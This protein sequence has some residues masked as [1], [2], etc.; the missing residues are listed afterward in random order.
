MAVTA[1]QRV[2]D[3]FSVDRMIEAYE[4]LYRNLSAESHYDFRRT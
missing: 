2:E 3:R 4:D 1:R